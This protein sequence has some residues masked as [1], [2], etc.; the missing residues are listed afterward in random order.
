MEKVFVEVLNMGLTATW[1]VLAVL[2]VRALCRK[3]PKS[4]IV[5]LWALVGLR[6]VIPF[7]PESVTSLLPSG[8][9]VS[10][11]ILTAEEP[12]IFTGVAALN[13]AINPV[14]SEH[15]SPSYSISS[16]TMPGTGANPMQTV[17]FAA[18][19]VWFAG[20]AVMFAYSLGSYL[21]LRYKVRVSLCWRD[22]IYVCDSIATPF[23]FGLIKPR[24]YIPSG[25]DEA[26]RE[27]VI[28]HETAHL[29]RKDHWWKTIGFAL[30]SVYWFHPLLWISYLL[31]S[32]DI[33]RACDERVVKKLDTDA[34]KAYAEALVACSLQKRMMFACPLSFG[35]VGVKDRVKSVLHYK[36]PAFWI[37][38]G[39]VV[40][41]IVV[42]VC[43]LTNPLSGAK[44][45]DRNADT[46]GESIIGGADGPTKVFLVGVIDEDSI[47]YLRKQYP[48][49][50]DLD[51]SEGLELYVWQMG[52]SSYSCGL[53]SGKESRKIA[54]AAQAAGEIRTDLW[55]LRSVTINEMKLILSDYGIGK[56]KV[57]LI[58]YSMPYSSY[59]NVEAA[60]D[61]EGYLKR[62][63]AM[64]WGEE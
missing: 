36:K 21:W 32:R 3:A 34:R 37:V 9:I 1:V 61:P 57:K 33:E 40:A 43:F 39:T 20:M 56:E 28:A 10:P 60:K 16:A 11:E 63:E 7:V 35:E 53:L 46:A 24:I 59:L 31:F 26:Q 64:F 4:L 49:Y 38:V 42:A 50:F 30:L 44:T 48:E 22:N 2:A 27:C 12:S 13:M 23:V 25:M 5:C 29:K 47:R 58:P 45:P 19:V 41:G 55:H 8:R 6:L 62:L 17:A 51:T 52:G 15:L 18:M 14:L 54:E